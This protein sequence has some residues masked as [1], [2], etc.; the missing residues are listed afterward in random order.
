MQEAHPDNPSAWHTELRSLVD[1]LAEHKDHVIEAQRIIEAR[2]DQVTH[3]HK[4]DLLLCTWTQILGECELADLR[5]MT[6]TSHCERRTSFSYLC[7]L[8]CI[9]SQGKVVTTAMTDCILAAAGQINELELGFTLFDRYAA[10]QPPTTETYSAIIDG[11]VSCGALESVPLVCSWGECS[12]SPLLGPPPRGR[13]VGGEAHVFMLLPL[14][15]LHWYHPYYKAWVLLFPQNTSQGIL[16]RSCL[17]TELLWL[18]SSLSLTA[19]LFLKIIGLQIVK[20]MLDNGLK[21]NQQLLSS[22]AKFYIVARHPQGILDTLSVMHELRLRP[23]PELLEMAMC[24]MEREGHIDGII[25]LNEEI[26]DK[27]WTNFSSERLVCL[28]CILHLKPT[29]PVS[30]NKPCHSLTLSKSS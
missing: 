28:L 21:V 13:G 16:Q 9:V 1:C 20:E 5:I 18:S 8:H 30:S 10:I 23:S 12:A 11:C 24:R 17:H 7:K 29:E 3:Q 27:D 26:G 15:P 22:F 19:E 6:M 2:L 4:F 25:R 14:P